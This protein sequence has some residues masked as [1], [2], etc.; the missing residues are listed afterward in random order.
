MMDERGGVRADRVGVGQYLA[1]YA[2]I[3]A[4]FSEV[5]SPKHRHFLPLSLTC[6]VDSFV[7]RPPDIF[8]TFFE[9]FPENFSFFVDRVGLAFLS[10]MFLHLPADSQDL[11]GKASGN[12]DP[13]WLVSFL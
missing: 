13:Q 5:T 4:G 10:K 7:D 6:F 12:R 3:S 8:L 9:F 11:V 2:L 1:R